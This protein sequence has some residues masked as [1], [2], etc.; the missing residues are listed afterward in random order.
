[1]RQIVVEGLGFGIE[2]IIYEYIGHFSKESLKGFLDA[3]T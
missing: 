1:M 3:P 2:G